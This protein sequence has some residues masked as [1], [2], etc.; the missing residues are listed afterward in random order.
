MPASKL[1][2]PLAA[3]LIA[4]VTFTVGCA[5][6]EAEDAEAMGETASYVLAGDRLTPAEVAGQLRAAGFAENVIGRMVCTAKYESS[7]YDRASNKNRNGSTDRGLFQ[8]NSIHLGSMRGCPSKSAASSLFD[9]E[10]NVKCALAVYKAQ[11]IRA[12]YGYRAHKTECDRTKAPGSAPMTPRADDEPSTSEPEETEAPEPTIDPNDGYDLGAGCYSATTGTT[13]EPHSCV[14]QADSGTWFQCKQ[15]KWYR[16]GDD[17]RGPY[18]Y[19]NGAYP[20]E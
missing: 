17:V 15:G 13:M 8:I 18:G 4:L 12:W 16:G 9:P 20:L 11:G 3:L 10:T 7:Y 19:C 1:L 5:P 2:A 6:P 14:Q